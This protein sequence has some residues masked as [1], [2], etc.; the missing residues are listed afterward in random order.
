MIYDLQKGSIWKRIS[1]FLFDMILL[2]V[3]AALFALLLSW[4]TGY[5]GHAAALDRKY[6]E[7]GVSRDFA[8]Q[9]DEAT[10]EERAD[11]DARVAQLEDDPE[12]NRL[13]SLLVSLSVVITTGGVLLSFL[14]WEFFVPLWLRNGQTLGKK[15][16]GLAVMRTNSVRISGPSLFIRTILGKYAVETMIPVYLVV[17][18]FFNQSD[19]FQ[20]ILLFLIPLANLVLVL[21][22]GTHSCL[23][24]FLADTVVV[25][26]GSQMIFE[27]D[28]EMIEYKTRIHKETVG[29]SREQAPPRDLS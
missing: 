27:S 12:A 25:D 24:D 16:F 23:H 22:S 19:V 28:Q 13:F 14:L 4:I 3:L 2:S 5:D 1:A 20:L 21:A 29:Q 26:F 9:Y 17:M 8:E 10:D 11:Y 15:V 18:F 6:E 7:Y